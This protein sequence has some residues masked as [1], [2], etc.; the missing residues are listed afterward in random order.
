[1][2]EVIAKSY[3]KQYDV[4]VVIARLSTVYGPTRNIPDTAFYEFIRKA[5]EGLDITVNTSNTPKRDNIFVEDAVDGILTVALKGIK[6]ESYNISSNGELGNYLAIDEI[7]EQIIMIA[8][9]NNKKMV[10]NHLKPS[11]KVSR[12]P[13]LKLSNEKLKALG[14]SVKISHE[15]GIKRTIAYFKNMK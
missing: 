13:G 15:E 8:T 9:T 1:M 10:V 7:A 5:V 2:S 14:W 3:V 11:S 6:S 4:D 12:K